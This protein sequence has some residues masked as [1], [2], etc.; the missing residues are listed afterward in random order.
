MDQ[1]SKTKIKRMAKYHPD[2][3]LR[4][5]DKSWFSAYGK[6]LKNILKGW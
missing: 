6:L 3:V 2:V 1:K 4:V 5:V